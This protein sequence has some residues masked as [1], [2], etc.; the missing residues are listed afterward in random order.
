MRPIPFQLRYVASS[1]F[2][3]FPPGI[4]W[5]N[6]PCVFSKVENNIALR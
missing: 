3:R 1:A 5:L 4:G 2:V 6:L